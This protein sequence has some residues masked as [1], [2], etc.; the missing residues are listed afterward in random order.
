MG[1]EDQ[2]REPKVERMEGATAKVKFNH[3]SLPVFIDR[4]I[5]NRKRHSVVLGWVH[6]ASGKCGGVGAAA[7]KGGAVVQG[8]HSLSTVA[9]MVGAAVSAVWQWREIWR[10]RGEPGLKARPTPGRPAKLT[11]R[12]RQR[13]PRLLAPWAPRVTAIPTISGPRGGSPPSSSASLRS[14]TTR[15]R[16]AASWRNWAGV[17]R[18][19]NA[20][21]WNAM[22][23]PSPIG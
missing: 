12:Q 1:G 18:S 21:R 6:E 15:L 7:A 13:L 23:R 20:G 16:S 19:P 11:P 17:I 10:R 22:R 5:N 9:R 8:G 14:A 3:M 2:P 4:C